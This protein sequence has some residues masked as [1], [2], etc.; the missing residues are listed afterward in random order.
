MNVNEL[1][2]GKLQIEWDEN[3]PIESI[4]NTWTEEDFQ[5]FFDECLRQ[6]SGEFGEE[7]KEDYYNSES[8]GKDYIQKDDITKEG[9]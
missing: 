7:S 8:E 5:N 9:C 6:D 4:L 3:D 1:P 2:D